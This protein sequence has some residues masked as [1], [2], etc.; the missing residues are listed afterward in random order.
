MC[1]S[2][3]CLQCSSPSHWPLEPVVGRTS[4]CTQVLEFLNCNSSPEVFF[5]QV[6]DW[7]ARERSSRLVSSTQAVHASPL[8]PHNAKSR[9]SKHTI[10]STLQLQVKRLL[11]NS[12]LGSLCT[13]HLA[14][15]PPL[16]CILGENWRKVVVTPIMYT[17]WGNLEKSSRMIKMGLYF[18]KQYSHHRVEVS[19]TNK[20][21]ILQKGPQRNTNQY[22]V[23]NKL[24]YPTDLIRQQIQTCQST[25]NLICNVF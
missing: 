6:L 10:S 9:D 22:L 13:A 4:S 18:R 20:S 1:Y 5:P 7:A 11:W 16:Q 8:P 24:L 3:T 23:I 21:I 2:C 14:F 25:G 17:T 15:H 19:V 12:S